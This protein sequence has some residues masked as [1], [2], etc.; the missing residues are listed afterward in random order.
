MNLAFN[1]RPDLYGF[2]TM[3]VLSFT[4]DSLFNLSGR[5]LF[6]AM[7]AHQ[8]SGTENT[9]PFATPNNLDRLGLKVAIAIGLRILG[10][11]KSTSGFPN[12]GASRNTV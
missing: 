5:N 12:Q 6:V 3:L 4:I 2:V 7:L 11:V 9:F 8:A 10:H 1:I